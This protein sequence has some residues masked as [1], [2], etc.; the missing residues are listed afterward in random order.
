MHMWHPD[1]T[2]MRAARIL[3]VMPPEP[4]AE[5]ER[6]AIASMSGVICRTS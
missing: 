5:V 2:A 4:T 6:P 1:A 3:D